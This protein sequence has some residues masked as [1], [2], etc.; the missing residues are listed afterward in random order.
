MGAQVIFTNV[1]KNL[2]LLPTRKA[3]AKQYR[4]EPRR[5]WA[6]LEQFLTV[7][8]DLPGVKISTS[9]ARKR[10]KKDEDGFYRIPYLNGSRDNQW[11]ACTDL[12]DIAPFQEAYKLRLL[13]GKV[14]YW[15]SQLRDEL[16]RL[17][18]LRARNED[19]LSGPPPEP[20]PVPPSRRPTGRPTGRPRGGNRKT[21]RGSTDRGLTG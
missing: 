4:W 9:D 6:C 13:G 3:V 19:Y 7:E 16:L 2:R 10:I 14:V 17:R 18:K 12:K 15:F 5:K 21:A 11:F 8:P 20:R 1:L